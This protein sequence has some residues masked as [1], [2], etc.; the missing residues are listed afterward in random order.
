MTYLTP[1]AISA[2]E[3]IAAVDIGS[4][5]FHLVIARIVDGALQLLHR[6]KQKVQLADGLD[7]EQML[8][9]EAMQRGLLVLKQFADSLQ[10]MPPSSVRVIATYTL[11]RAKNSSE[12]L[13]QAQSVF[14]FPIEVISG[15]EEARFIYQGV[16]H[17]ETYPGQRLVI[18]IGGGSTEFAIGQHFDPIKLASRNMG[19][20]SYAKHF[21]PKGKITTK[22]FER[23]VLQA[24]QELENITS[25]YKDTGW[26]QVVGTS[27]TIKTIKDIIV[28]MGWNAHVIE[29]NHLLKLKN[30]LLQVEDCQD[31]NWPG[32]TDDRKTLIGPGLAILL[33]SFQMLGIE[34]MVYVDAALREGVL[35]EMS[36]RLQHHDIRSHTI[37]SLIKRYAVDT[38]QANRVNQVAQRLFLQVKEDWQ[39]DDNW[40]ELLQFAA[41]VYEIGLQ[42]NSS[43]VQ[44]HSAYILN[45][46]NL[47][48]FNQEQQKLLS[49]LVRSH[50]RKI[51][52]DDIPQFYLFSNLQFNRV[53]SIFRL[54]VLLNQKRR[55]ELTPELKLVAQ[56][57]QLTL[58]L[59]E[60][61]YQQHSVLAAD[62]AAE[63]Q[64]LR[65][66]NLQLNCPGL[67]QDSIEEL[68]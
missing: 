30:L 4:N 25:A 32:L 68:T 36:D 44:R 17:F 50:R 23:A 29:L 54:S 14:P 63:Q 52:V 66:I 51:K 28:A 53:L 24:E 43:S 62:L 21:F 15:Q 38:E 41:S 19:C 61:W 2:A 46:S 5:S 37:Q 3:L 65:R 35:Y 60:E 16:A 58:L 18:D 7:A 27:G 49:C 8:S 45:N 20:V 40:A 47:P 64:Y 59:T 10:G 12:F 48:G 34:Q 1:S 56:G 67:P 9:D 11:R 42:I 6:E 22:R 26:Q 31:L 13:K 57:D 55:D 33:A 39:L